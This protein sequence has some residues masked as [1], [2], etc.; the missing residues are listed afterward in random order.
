MAY[1][2]SKYFSF[3]NKLDQ[4]F[5]EVYFDFQEI[6]Q[7]IF[8]AC[9]NFDGICKVKSSKHV[10]EIRV[11][12][13]D[14]LT[15]ILLLALRVMTYNSGWS[16]LKVRLRKQVVLLQ[17]DWTSEPYMSKSKTNLLTVWPQHMSK[18]GKEKGCY[19]CNLGYKGWTS[20]SKITLKRN[21]SYLGK[22]KNPVDWCWP[23]NQPNLL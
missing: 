16:Y 21:K 15:G 2:L 11:Y 22:T 14:F 13:F 7:N 9:L 19:L 8:S 20:N 1:N 3:S 23:L 12:F 6:I 5:S 10:I 17:Q 4:Y 18:S